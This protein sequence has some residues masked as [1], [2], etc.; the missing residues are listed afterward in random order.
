M[1]EIYKKA[2]GVFAWVGEPDFQE[3]STLVLL[4]RPVT[5]VVREQTFSRFSF[6]QMRQFCAKEYWLRTWIQQEVILARRVAI[7]CGDIIIP[8]ETF[9]DICEP[10]SDSRDET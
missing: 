1:G 4:H 5:D 8:W 7:C 3:R 6:Y 9:V 10:S 2:S